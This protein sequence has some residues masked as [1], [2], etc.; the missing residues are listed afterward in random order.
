MK[1]KVLALASALV[2]TCVA[3]TPA[4]AHQGHTSCK[5]FGATVS[6]NA[7]AERPWGQIVS[8]GAKAGLTAALTAEAHTTEGL[9]ES[10]G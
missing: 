8:G 7:Q 6:G 2:L 3:A 9:C 4:S 1:R 10:H 5:E